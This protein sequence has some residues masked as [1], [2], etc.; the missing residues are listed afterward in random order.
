MDTCDPGTTFGTFLAVFDECPDPWAAVHQANYLT[1]AIGT[2]D[3]APECAGV[4][5]VN[6][7]GLSRASRVEAIVDHQTTD[8]W[9]IFLNMRRNVI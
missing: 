1:R 7:A 2:S 5:A 4:G 3:D 9:G 6:G 8:M